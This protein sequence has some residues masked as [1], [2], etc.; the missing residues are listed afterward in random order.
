V[1]FTIELGENK[2]NYYFK[3]ANALPP[4]E[5]IKLL[6]LFLRSREC[7]K[8]HCPPG[9]SSYGT[10][11][12]GFYWV[13][14][15]N[16][17][18]GM[19]NY[20]GAL[21]HSDQSK[22]KEVLYIGQSIL[23]RCARAL[24]ARDAMGFEYF[25]GEDSG[26]REKTIYHFDYLTLL[27]S[28]SFDA[29]AKVAWHVYKIDPKKVKERDVSFRKKDFI[30]ALKENGAEDLVKLLATKK[31]KDITTLLYELRNTIHGAANPVVRILGKG[32]FIVPFEQ[33]KKKLFDAAQACGPVE[34]WGME[35]K[36]GSNFVP[37][38]YAKTLVWECFDLL[39]EIVSVTDVSKLFHDGK[40]P[41]SLNG[42]PKDADGLFSSFV[43]EKVLALG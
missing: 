31:F 43:Q 37:Y 12:G 29:A 11:E 8:I 28:G 24:I 23:Q 10:D 40:L 19:W 35:P 33:Y 18:P 42:P 20:F 4:V 27:L 5:A 16:K 7:F 14:V 21:V 25:K 9:K 2:N 41:A 30:E 15:R 36:D 39:N 1:H 13:L 17:L 22:E 34:R 32:H 6:G 38:I 3:Q 26:S